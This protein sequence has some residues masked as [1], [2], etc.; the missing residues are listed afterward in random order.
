MSRST[1]TTPVRG[2]RGAFARTLPRP[3]PLRKLIIAISWRSTGFDAPIVQA[4][5][6]DRPQRDHTLRQAICR[7][8]PPNAS[9]RPMA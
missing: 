6:L 4:M 9:R 8:S 3:Q 7:V 5:H 2:T 1:R